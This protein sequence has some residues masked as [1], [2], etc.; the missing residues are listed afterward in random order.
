MYCIVCTIQILNVLLKFKPT[1]DSC[2]CTIKAVEYNAVVALP[3]RK[4]QV[5]MPLLFVKAISVTK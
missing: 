5:K 1:I 3:S 4:G 2:K